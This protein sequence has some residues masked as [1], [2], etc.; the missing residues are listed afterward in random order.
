MFT[1]KSTF[2]KLAKN[3]YKAGNLFIGL[4]EDMYIISSNYWRME[5]R[6]MFLDKQHKAALVE[7]VGDLPEPGTI[8][9]YVDGEQAER[10]EDKPVCSLAKT[11]HN[12]KRSLTATHISVNT[13]GNATLRMMEDVQTGEK[14]YVNGVFPAMI[15]TSAVQEE[16]GETYP[17]IDPRTDGMRC[18]W[19]NNVMS[20]MCY[21]RR[22]RYREEEELLNI[23]ASSELA[24]S[25]TSD[26]EVAY[27]EDAR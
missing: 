10:I 13:I 4:T 21:L 14:V 27:G 16:D 23:L 19:S 3:A 18:I 6:Q 9:R 17:D 7:L 26:N 24:Y 5:V 15:R 20:L 22:P 12:M 2:K 1:N 25:F 11:W 8:Y